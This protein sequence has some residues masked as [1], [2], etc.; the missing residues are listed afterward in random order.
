MV[1]ASCGELAGD[2]GIV[3]V[4]GAVVVVVVVGAGLDEL[5]ERGVASELQPMHTA[6]HTTAAARRIIEST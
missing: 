4:V 5:A 3:V 1:A 6:A 2:S